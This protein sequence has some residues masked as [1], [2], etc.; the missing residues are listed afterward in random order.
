MDIRIVKSYVTHCEICDDVEELR[1]SWEAE[2]DRLKAEND[3]YEI[4]GFKGVPGYI[5]KDSDEYKYSIN[6]V[7][8]EKCMHA[9]N[10]GVALINNQKLSG[11]SI[12]TNK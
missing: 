2:Q 9:I 12:D 7:F 1:Y 4:K 8:C 5:I 6:H 11:V 10:R 3:D